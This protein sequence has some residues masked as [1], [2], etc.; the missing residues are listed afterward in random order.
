MYASVSPEC[1]ISLE[2]VDGEDY[3]VC[4][5]I[6]NP[7]ETDFTW[8]LSNENDTLQQL[9]VTRGGKS[10]LLIDPYVAQPRTYLCRANNTIGSSTTCEKEVQ[11]EDIYID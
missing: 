9:P 7:E 3:V 10:Y 11:G 4:S 6:A 1:Q 8:E 2:E 5:A